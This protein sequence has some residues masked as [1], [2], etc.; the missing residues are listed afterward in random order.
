MSRPLSYSDIAPGVTI[1]NFLVMEKIAQGGMGAVFKGFDPALERS[2]AIKVLRPEYAQDE[3]YLTFFQQEARAVAALR[4]GNIVPIYTIG[5]EGEILYFAMAFIEGHTFDDWIDANHKMDAGDAQW[6]MT[7]A[8]AA[9]ECAWRNKI[10]HLDIKPANFMIDAASVVMLT[11]FG[12]A[13]NVSVAQD[14]D[15]EREAFGTP[16]Y[17]SPEQ[18]TRDRTDLRT[19]IYSLGATLFHL[20]V[21]APPFDGNTVEEIVWGHLEKPF[22]TRKALEA[23]VPQ[24]WISLMRKMMERLPADRF[25]DYKQ[26]R[27]ALAD[28]DHFHHESVQ[29]QHPLANM[30]PEEEE[31]SGEDEEEVQQLTAA[32]RAAANPDLLHGLLLPSRADWSITTSISSK[33]NVTRTQVKEAILEPSEPLVLTSIAQTLLDLCRVGEVTEEEVDV[34]CEK[35]P[36]FRDAMMSI[37]QFM[38]NGDEAED[39]ADAVEVLGPERVRNMAL[40]F[41]MLSYDYKGNENYQFNVFWQHSITTGFIV[42]FMYDALDLKRTGLEYVSGL[43]HDVGKLLLAEIY[44]FAFFG[45]MRQSI[46]KTSSM[47]VEERSAFGIDHAEIGALWLNS[48][49]F[50]SQ[51][52]SA[53]ALH[54]NL[55]NPD[56]TKGKHLLANALISAN[57]LC[58]Q[59]GIGYS[60]D[61]WLPA[62]WPELDA[63]RILWEARRNTDYAFEDFTE[64]FLSQ[65]EQFPELL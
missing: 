53:I 28:V 20:M 27:A 64:D 29:H 50:P 31:Q 44:P 56:L 63:T 42:D 32:P 39:E 43:T 36:G 17:V 52:T 1:G 7:Q 25:Q 40:T 48:L 21:G 58:K 62:A 38:N 45:V 54:E 4:H 59:L 8:V 61:A 46:I 2:V 15:S 55:D 23:G 13:Q 65:F 47:A 11:D 24:G 34:A 16:A 12:L 26:L 57:G 30:A 10:V 33:L 41:W 49:D 5:V 14:A 37:A 9:L 22:P 51:L 35:F 60:G 6:F 3:E 19:D 18:I